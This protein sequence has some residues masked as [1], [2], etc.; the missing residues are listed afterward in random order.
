MSTPE[1]V[2]LNPEPS[3]HERYSAASQEREPAL[4]CPVVYDQQYLEVIPQEIIDRDYGCGDPS[5]YVNE[6]DVVVDLGSGGGKLCY[7][8]SQQVG[9]SGRVI[10]VDVNQDMLELAKGYQQEVADKIGYS[11]VEFR[12]GKIQDLALDLDVLADTMDSATEGMSKE[13]KALELI[14]LPEKLRRQS[15]MIADNSVDCVVSNCVLNLVAPADR[16]QLFAEIFRVL[17]PGG[18]AAIS[19]I[20]SDEDVPMDLQED[21]ELWSGCISGAWREDKFVDEFQDAGFSGI[22]IDKRQEEAWQTVKGIEFRSVTLLAY[23]PSSAVCLERNQ[24]VIYKG[25]FESVQDED[26]HVYPRGVRMAVCDRTFS[27]L[28]AAPYAGQFIPVEPIKEIPLDQA[29]EY[30]CK[31]N[32]TRDPRE[33]K[34]M[35]YNL[36]IQS[37]GEDCCGGGSDSCC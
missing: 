17:K 23:K 32:R 27:A 30:D 13:E 34:G 3:V 35:Q 15:P 4:C 20:V 12:Y 25:P 11:N 10:G 21:G 5:P 7:I 31:V 26:G 28:Q 2:Q 6:G 16:R 18:K 8:I 24:A 29:Q 14:D 36:T 9:E 33:T 19:D 1:T 37:T 22:V